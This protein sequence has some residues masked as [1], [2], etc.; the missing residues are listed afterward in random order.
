M[1]LLWNND[2][3]TEQVAKQY[4]PIGRYKIPS[5][6][7]DGCNFHSAVWDKYVTQPS[8]WPKEPF[9][10][11]PDQI[12]IQFRNN[13]YTQAIA[14]VASWG[15]M[16]RTNQA[17]WNRDAPHIEVVIRDCI[18]KIRTSKSIESAWTSLTGR[19]EVQ[20]G[21]SDV[22]A[23]KTLNFLCR[24]IGF[25]QNPPVPIDGKIII[26]NVWPDFRRHAGQLTPKPWRQKGHPF[27]ACNRYMAAMQIWSSQKKRTTAHVEATIFSKFSRNNE[28]N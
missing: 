7:F 13:R 16:W 2:E 15:N 14:M 22:M 18:N 3:L 5:A 10:S 6:Q 8:K 25:E 17:I 20:L 12:I 23:S 4:N 9:R 21:W 1:K 19:A 27:N 11:S 24:S 28:N 26:K